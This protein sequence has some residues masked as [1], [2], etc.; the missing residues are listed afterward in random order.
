MSVSLLTIKAL[1][2]PCI[3][4]ESL[5]FVHQKQLMP[6]QNGSGFCGEARLSPGSPGET[7]GSTRY[8]S[9]EHAAGATWAIGVHRVSRDGKGVRG[10]ERKKARLF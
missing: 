2:F 9:D 7:I 1:Y 10:G 5:I 6:L 3:Y 8:R 4:V